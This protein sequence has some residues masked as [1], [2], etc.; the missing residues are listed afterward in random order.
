[1]VSSKHFLSTALCLDSLP[2]QLMELCP[3]CMAGT[4]PSSKSAGSAPA[5][6]IAVVV[7]SSER[8]AQLFQQLKPMSK[9]N[10]IVKA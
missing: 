3:A 4:S 10:T 2:A 9:G 1:M 7:S 8:G 5:P 6:L